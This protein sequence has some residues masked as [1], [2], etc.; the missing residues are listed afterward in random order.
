MQLELK[1]KAQALSSPVGRSMGQSEFAGGC[2]N[3]MQPAQVKRV[4]IRTL[5]GWVC[6]SLFTIYMATTKQLPWS[7]PIICI[8]VYAFLALG[9]IKRSEEHTSELQSQ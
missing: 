9:V 6:A 8:P 7:V 4:L 2:C 5:A 1:H 3:I